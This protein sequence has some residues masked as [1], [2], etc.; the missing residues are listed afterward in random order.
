VYDLSK[1]EKIIIIKRW[2]VT[3]F[4]IRKQFTCLTC[5]QIVAL[6]CSRKNFEVVDVDFFFFGWNEKWKEVSDTFSPVFKLTT[7]SGPF[8]GNL[9]IY[10]F[11]FSHS[12]S[13]VLLISLFFFQ[14]Q[15][16]KVCKTFI[17]TW[18]QWL[19]VQPD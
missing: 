18:I 10:F 7:C 17:V 12:F 8:R 6:S 14:Q 5:I 16:N 9:F 3:I 2:H 4:C 19:Y 1:K 15:S 13:R 11:P